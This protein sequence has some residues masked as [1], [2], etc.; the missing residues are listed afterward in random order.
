MK[1]FS[2]ILV[3]LIVITGFCAIVL[4]ILLLTWEA[5]A[6]EK[7]VQLPPEKRFKV[8]TAY[9]E[10]SGFQIYM[11]TDLQTG[12]EYIVSRKGE[13]VSTVPLEVD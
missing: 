7:P 4:P 6:A 5:N 9:S 3:P 13:A 11:I 2:D 10:F 8:V 1:K 12:R